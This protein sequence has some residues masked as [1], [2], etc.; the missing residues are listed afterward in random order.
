[1]LIVSM[2]FLRPVVVIMPFCRDATER[3]LVD[4]QLPRVVGLQTDRLGIAAVLLPCRQYV[5]PSNGPDQFGLLAGA[6]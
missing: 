1:V 5:T 4:F 6:V 3:E 2:N